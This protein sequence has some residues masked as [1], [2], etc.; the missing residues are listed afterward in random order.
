MSLSEWLNYY[1]EVT[2]GKQVVNNS[3]FIGRLSIAVMSL[4]GCLQQ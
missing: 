4:E 1:Y 3:D 2:Y